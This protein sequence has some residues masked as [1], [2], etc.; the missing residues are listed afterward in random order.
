MSEIGKLRKNT[1]ETIQKRKD[2]I[3]KNGGQKHT[4]EVKKK[5]SD[6]TKMWWKKFKVEKIKF[7]N[8]GP[9]GKFYKKGQIN[10]DKSYNKRD[11]NGKFLKRITSTI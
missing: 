1:K 11:K 6:V 8:R 10:F 5:L 7:Q 3:K 9:D 2:T 4:D